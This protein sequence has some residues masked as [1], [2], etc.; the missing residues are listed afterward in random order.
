MG[1]GR[2]GQASFVSKRLI[3]TFGN[4]FL[5]RIDAGVGDLGASQTWETVDGYQSHRLLDR[6]GWLVDTGLRL[7]AECGRRC[8]RHPSARSTTN[9]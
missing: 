7:A 8:S 6:R 3:W 1:S 9:L 5:S 2:L 4:A